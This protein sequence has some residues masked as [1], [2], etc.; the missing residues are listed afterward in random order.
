MMRFIELID[1]GLA[2]VSRKIPIKYII[3]SGSNMTKRLKV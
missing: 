3:I 1:L 2:G